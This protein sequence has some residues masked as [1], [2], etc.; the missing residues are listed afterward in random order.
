MITVVSG[1]LGAGKSYDVADRIIQHLIRGGIV[2]TNMSVDLE[3]IRKIYKRRLRDWQ[4]IPLS[5][6][7]DP[8]RIPRGDLRGAGRRRV[9][10]VLDEA[11]NWFES[12]ATAK[13]PRRAT[14]GE[15]LRQSDKLGQDVIF[16]AQ[17]F[18]RAAKW[19]RELAQLSDDVRNFGQ[20]RMFGLPVGK[21]L[22]LGRVYIVVHA[23]V[24]TRQVLGV[25]LGYIN[26]NVWRC[27]RTAEL[28]GFEAAQNAYL[29][30]SVAPRY[31]LPLPALGFVIPAL[32]A[33]V[34]VFIEVIR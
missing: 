24:K 9:L 27:Y 7:D 19:I 10:V 22:H 4:L 5:A 13:D 1:K 23:D 32:W 2:A 28:Y 15:W 12:S 6:D 20:I 11:L 25:T 26:S 16:I 29:G 3:A 8:R 18:S 21:W 14:W 34:R 33:I 17:D 31:N 30:H